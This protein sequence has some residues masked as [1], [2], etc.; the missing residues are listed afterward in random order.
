MTEGMP[1][2]PE[3]RRYTLEQTAKSG[4]RW[5]WWIAGMSAINSIV[6]WLEM[7]WGFFIGLGITQVFDAFGPQFGVIGIA[8]A[9]VL[10]MIV[11]A[12]FVIL[13]SLALRH[14]SAY[15]VGIILYALD[16]VLLLAFGDF[17]AAGFHLF[18]IF[19]I[20]KGLSAAKALAAEP[21]PA[22]ASP[23]TMYGEQFAPAAAAATSVPLP[24]NEPF[25]LD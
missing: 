6:W 9:I 14:R 15:I 24:S 2:S 21:P 20:S 25:D 1:T 11:V 10:D 5:F 12:V 3:L 13:G 17:L 16:G 8:V 23:G 22:V 18:A 7:R 19:F 4:A